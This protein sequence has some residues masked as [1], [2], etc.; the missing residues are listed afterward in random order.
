M[1]RLTPEDFRTY[2]E[3]EKGAILNNRANN[4]SKVDGN[5]NIF[6]IISPIIV[7]SLPTY[8]WTDEPDDNSILGSN[9]H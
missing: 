5:P 6:A 3:Y 7:A 8:L 9:I 4:V 1:S 2:F